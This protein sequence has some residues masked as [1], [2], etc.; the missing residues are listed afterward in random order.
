M[1]ELEKRGIPTV[2]WT[3]ERF[4][5]DAQASALAFGLTTIPIAIIPVPC[6]NEP[7]D[8]IR[9]MAADSIDQ[10]IDGLTKPVSPKVTKVAARPSKVLKFQAED[11]LEA[12]EKMNK[13]FLDEGWSDGFPLVPPTSQAVE[14]MLSGTSFS[15]EKV[16]CLLEPG[17]GIATVEKIAIN[18]VMAGCR[19]EHL[20]VV[21]TAVQCLSDPK[22]MLRNMAVST[23]PHAPLIIVNGPIAKEININAKACA[24]GPGS[25]SYANT[26]IGRSLRLIMMNVGHCYPGIL[27][28]DTIGSPTKYS[29][30]VAE[31]EDDNPWEPFHVERGYDKDTSTVTVHFNYGV[32]D[33]LDIWSTTPEGLM[34]RYSSSPINI[35]HVGAGLWLIGRRSDPRYHVQAKDHDFILMCPDHARIFANHN[36]DKDKIRQ[37]LYEQALAPFK[38]L[39]KDMK[40]V[41][42]AHPELMWL[43]DH[44]DLMLPV[45]E[46][47]DCFEIAVVGADVGRSIFFWGANEPVTKPIEGKR[48]L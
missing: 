10:V 45:L 20:P 24:L 22:T 23:G 28:M 37:T 46:T 11:L 3:A 39:F 43:K 31:N 21:I 44:P 19:P 25:I 4:I 2:S 35:G 26:V 1:F 9:Q 30:C 5:D 47:P 27:D 6:T 42:A 18:A 15:R 40:L 8:R 33:L 38:V 12:F 34:E 32:C 41:K 48:R 17:N 7:A 13:S 36:W 16:I 29:M 14:H